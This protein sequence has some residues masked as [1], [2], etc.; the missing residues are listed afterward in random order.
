MHCLDKLR[1][2]ES[3]TQTRSYRHRMNTTTLATFL[4]MYFDGHQ[5]NT[6]NYKAVDVEMTNWKFLFNFLLEYGELDTIDCAFPKL[7]S[8]IHYYEKSTIG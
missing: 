2:D 3:E 8:L 1:S 7:I 4:F 6:F 5:A